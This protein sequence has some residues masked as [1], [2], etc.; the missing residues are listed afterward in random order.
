MRNKYRHNAEYRL[1]EQTR[2]KLIYHRLK[3][4]K[5]AKLATIV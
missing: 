4:E 5:L 2:N 1:K 3:E